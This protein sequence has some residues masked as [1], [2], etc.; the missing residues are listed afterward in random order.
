MTRTSLPP[1]KPEILH[2]GNILNNG[3]LHCKYL[4]K[5][6]IQADCLNVDYKHCQGQPE[7][8]EV[9]IDE[10]VDEFSPDW[11]KVQLKGFTRPRWFYDVSPRELI[12]LSER[13]GDDV[14]GGLQYHGKELVQPNNSSVPPHIL[15]R[16]YV[17]EMLDSLGIKDKV[18]RNLIEPIHQYKRRV[19]HR[20]DLR[21][22][23]RFLLL[24]LFDLIGYWMRQVSWE[25]RFVHREMIEEYAHHFPQ[26]QARL[27]LGDI[28]E[29]CPRSLNYK[30]VLA[31]YKLVH[32][33]GLNPIHSILCLPGLPFICYEHGTLRDF[34]FED[35]ARGRLYRLALK[36]AEKVIITNADCNRSADRL[37]LENAVFIPHIIDDDLFKPEESRLRETLQRETGCDFIIVAPSR[38]HWKNCP[39]GLENSW[40]KRNDILIRG[41]GRVFSA[42]PQIK[43]LVVFFEWGAE[44]E[45][46]KNL[47]AEC[48]FSENVQWEQIRSKPVL[49]DF[50]CA[51]DII[52]DQFNSG[53]GTFGAVV[54]ESMACGKPVILN[55]DKELHRWCYPEL[56]PAI[57]APTEESVAENVLKLIDDRS[58]RLGL[59]DQGR[60]WFENYHSSQVVM[61]RLAAVYQ[62]IS[63]KHDWGWRYC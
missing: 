53:I 43:I 59:G 49:K 34:P 8:A 31:K 37:G 60:A 33:Y 9:Y 39:P 26:Q 13:I 41:L 61:D 15:V 36:K 32:A 38:H 22:G 3:Y 51:A 5:R 30:P 18:L 12:R 40:L 54:P 10:P 44:V 6:N 2:V 16:R 24:R 25:Q 45:E 23:F 62:E 58:Y 47:I 48:G 63:D 21:K 46:S 27:S 1:E 55:Y 52:L 35:S 4:R 19:G 29:W 57:H 11:S 42:R 56:P 17:G 14:S 28:I 20:E 50:Y 7:W